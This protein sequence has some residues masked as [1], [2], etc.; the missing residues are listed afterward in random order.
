[1]VFVRR[2]QQLLLHFSELLIY[3]TCEL[4]PKEFKA[5]LQSEYPPIHLEMIGVEVDVL[6]ES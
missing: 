4:F 1:M 3:T 6:L 2:L 5:I